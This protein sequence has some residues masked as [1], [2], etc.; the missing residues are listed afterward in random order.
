TITLTTRSHA[1]RPLH[2]VTSRTIASSDRPMI[3]RGCSIHS[4]CVNELAGSSRSVRHAS[5]YEETPYSAPRRQL[6]PSRGAIRQ[7][8]ERNR[9]LPRFQLTSR[10]GHQ[11]RADDSIRQLSY[12]GLPGDQPHPNAS[13]HAAQR[14]GLLSRAAARRYTPTSLTGPVWL[15]PESTA[16]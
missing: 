16:E 7:R 4:P 9:Y 5:R 13:S 14:A 15:L 2:A 11:R 1:K 8:R 10:F 3:P 6:E 12:R